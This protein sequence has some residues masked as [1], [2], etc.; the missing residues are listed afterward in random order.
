MER[1]HRRPA[2]SALDPPLREYERQ[3]GGYWLYGRDPCG[4]DKKWVPLPG[5]E[6]HRWPWP[7]PNQAGT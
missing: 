1:P 7:A 4:D 3:Q 5:R 2:E 6:P